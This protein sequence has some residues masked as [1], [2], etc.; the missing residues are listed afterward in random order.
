MISLVYALPVGNALRVFLNPIDGAVRWRVLRKEVDTFSGAD[1]ADAATVLDGTDRSALDY[2]GLVNG[3]EYWYAAYYQLEDDS[4]VASDAKSGTPLFSLSDRTEDVYAVVSDRVFSGLESYVAAGTLSP[5][6]GSIPVLLQTPIFDEVPFPVVT[7]HFRQEAPAE[8]FIGEG[9]PVDEFIGADFS[10][11][12][13]EGYLARTTITV[14]G[15]SLNSTERATLRN[16]LRAV[17][18]GN[19]SVFDAIGIQTPDLSVSDADDFQS[20]SAP[21]YQ[22]ECTLSCLAPVVV[23]GV[24]DAIRDVVSTMY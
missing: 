19:F 1:D 12:V 24:E 9:Y 8:R 14:V 5:S 20:Y 16:A 13:A 22:V 11:E 4:W 17:L 23:S 15:H 6:S 3:V 18:V 10:W 2:A 7:V 21:V